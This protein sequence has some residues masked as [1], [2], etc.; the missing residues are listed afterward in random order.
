MA[1]GSSAFLAHLADA[2]KSADPESPCGIKFGPLIW[3]ASRLGDV[4]LLGQLLR[5]MSHSGTTGSVLPKSPAERLAWAPKDGPERWLTSLCIA[6]KNGH[7]EAVRM[8]LEAEGPRRT[9]PKTSHNRFA[10]GLAAFHGH[11]DV[12]CLLLQAG[13]KPDASMDLMSFPSQ[14]ATSLQL[15]II[16]RH[17]GVVEKLLAAGASPDRASRDDKQTPLHVAAREL[18]EGFVVALLKAGANPNRRNASGD[19][20][21]LVAAMSSI[22]GPNDT[23][24]RRAVVA[25]LLGAGAK[26]A[27]TSESTGLS[28]LHAFAGVGDDH[29]VSSLI[30][31]GSPVNS[32]T[33]FDGEAPL[34]RAA[35]NGHEGV[36]RM[37]LGAGANVDAVDSEEETPL[38]RACKNGHLE[39][40]KRLMEA[41]ADIFA[42]CCA[43]EA[44]SPVE[45]AAANGH[46]DVLEQLIWTGEDKEVP[47]PGGDVEYEPILREGFEDETGP[48]QS[49]RVGRRKRPRRSDRGVER[50]SVRHQLSGRHG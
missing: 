27:T 14:V 37:L 43:D 49:P 22:Q 3:G 34:H 6:A 11:A 16:G 36:V 30:S 10:L 18:H 25:R 13:M 39:V 1:A 5:T 45:I 31:L 40:V 41:G 33:I 35:E 8:L 44:Q 20:P 4:E 23:D 9:W 12:V 50:L 42:M 46:V 19:T 7:V 47:T 48:G 21:L 38:H 17:E 2:A 26:L 32:A 29:I 15:A 28:T 24:A